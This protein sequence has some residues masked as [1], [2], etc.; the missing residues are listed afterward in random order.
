MKKTA[1]QFAFLAAVAASTSATAAPTNCGTLTTA[2]ATVQAM[3]A[4]RD[5][6]SV[7]TDFQKI[8]D[9]ADAVRKTCME[10]LSA[11]DT[12]A[13]GVN[14]SVTRLLMQQATRICDA[15]ANQAQ[16]YQN[17]AVD[18]ARGALDMQLSKIDDTDAK[19]AARGVVSD[20]ASGN[21]TTES[22]WSRMT[23]WFVS[24]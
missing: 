20:A 24:R 23:N 14:S 5:V 17:T 7:M 2:I 3:S 13:T 6:Q 16:Q 1:R 4:D 9:A 15:A 12:T 21:T 22:V 10:Q 18:K 8:R 11:I 19:N